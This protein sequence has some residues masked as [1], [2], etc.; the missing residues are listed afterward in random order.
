MNSYPILIELKKSHAQIIKMPIFSHDYIIYELHSFMSKLTAGLNI[1]PK[2][3][4]PL[5]L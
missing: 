4:M 1:D 3:K 2:L 5:K